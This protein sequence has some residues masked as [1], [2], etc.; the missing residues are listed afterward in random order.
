MGIQLVTLVEQ[1]HKVGMVYGD[2]KPDNILVG[3]HR[4]TANFELHLIDYG[5]SRTF[6]NEDG[7]HI[8]PG[9]ALMSG[10]QAFAPPSSARNQVQSRRDD[11]WSIFLLLICLRT[12]KIPGLEDCHGMIPVL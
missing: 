9:F 1:V 10:N 7:S 5:L 6:I 2:L 8:K 4:Q 11:L 12:T 3:K